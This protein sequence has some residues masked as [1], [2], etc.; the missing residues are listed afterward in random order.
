MKRYEKSLFLSDIHAPYEDD[1][2][3]KVVCEFSEWFKPHKVFIL[4]DLVDFYQLSKFDKNPLR[5]DHLQDDIDIARSCLEMIRTSNPKAQ[6]WLFEGN[7]CTRLRKWLWSHPEIASLRG[8]SINE[9]LTLRQY[10]VHWVPAL[11]DFVHHGIYL[12]HGDIVRKHSAYTA[13]GMMEKRGVSGISGHTHRAGMHY[14]TN[15]GG[16][17]V[18]VENGCLCNRNPEYVKSPN[19]Q[20]AF[21][22]GYFKNDRFTMSQ[23]LIPDG[24]AVYAGKEFGNSI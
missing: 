18:W 4:G 23:V 3:M 17:F 16:D 15:M 14:L 2:S 21:T 19:W 11:D 5:M 10:N 7:H 22:V 8:L 12:E 13:R 20:N 1:K 9:L 24:K 6:I